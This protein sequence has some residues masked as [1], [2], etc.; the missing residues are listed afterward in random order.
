MV[1]HM[2]RIF[3]PFPRVL[4]IFTDC[5]LSVLP[6]SPSSSSP[7][8]FFPA[9]RQH[10]SSFSGR[11][12]GTIHS[13]SQSRWLIYTITLI[14]SLENGRWKR[15]DK[16]QKKKELINR[17]LRS[18]VRPGI[19]KTM[20]AE[21]L[22]VLKCQDWTPHWLVYRR[23]L[24]SRVASDG[25]KWVEKKTGSSI[26]IWQGYW[27]FQW[28]ATGNQPRRS[29]TREHQRWSC[30]RSWQENAKWCRFHGQERT[31]RLPTAREWDGKRQR[32]YNLP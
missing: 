9:G 23:R 2:L 12:E 4:L 22:N 27:P 14:S 3:W 24:S 15:T 18:N 25:S 20:A 28:N 8:S 6:S 5:L 31:S 19:P 10:L 26:W 21:S 13:S 29:S 32:A 1:T 11:G 16:R 7:P 17:L 30:H